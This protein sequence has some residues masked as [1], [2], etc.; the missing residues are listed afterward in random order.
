MPHMLSDNVYI[1]QQI[2]HTVTVHNKQLQNI[3]TFKYLRRVLKMAT[4]KHAKLR[5]VPIMLTC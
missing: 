5:F 1:N 4:S 2:I 3:P